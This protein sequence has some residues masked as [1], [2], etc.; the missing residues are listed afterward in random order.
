MSPFSVP[1]A[2]GGEISD[3]VLEQVIAA[4]ERLASGHFT[5]ADGTLFLLTAAPLFRETL[6]WRRK[7]GVIRE[8]AL[9][10]NVV[11]LRAG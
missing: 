3:P 4:A 8:M 7:A 6:N 5:E 1:P 2:T 9:P 10:D 11:M